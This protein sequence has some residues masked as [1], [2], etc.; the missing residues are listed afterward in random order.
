MFT[1]FGRR[2]GGGVC[3][4]I[5]SAFIDCQLRVTVDSAGVGV[6]AAWEA[7]QRAQTSTEG[8]THGQT[9]AKLQWSVEGNKSGAEPA[10]HADSRPPAAFE[11][12]F[13]V[14]CLL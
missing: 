13:F 3:E 9:P 2:S 14:F 12:I 7:P 1:V 10:A 6:T 5:Y 8:R 11:C 4:G